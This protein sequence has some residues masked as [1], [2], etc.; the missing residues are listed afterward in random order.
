MI[1]FGLFGLA[2][3]Q[4]VPKGIELLKRQIKT[5]F[6]H[7]VKNAFFSRPENLNTDFGRHPRGAK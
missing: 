4:D 2:V 6:I 1:E 7:L 5:R 3:V